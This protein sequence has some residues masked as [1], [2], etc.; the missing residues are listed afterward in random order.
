MHGL[1]E[2]V[3]EWQYGLQQL[4]QSQLQAGSLAAVFAVFA[5]GVLTS[6]TPCVYPMIPVTVT[7][8][9]GASAGRR[10]RA[11]ALSLVYVAGLA[12]IYAALG[13]TAALL[14]KTFG[15]F[16]RTWWIFGGVGLL[17]IVM[18]LAMMGW[19]DIPVPGF[20]AKV[21]AEGSRRGG[22][23]GA[24]FVGLAAG[25]VAAPCTAP[26]L[27]TLLVYVAGAGAEGSAGAVLW[28]GL[29]L[30][31]F[32]LGLG[33]LLMVL[34][35]FSGLLTNL[36]PPGRWMNLVKLVFGVLIILVGLWFLVQ[37]GGILIDS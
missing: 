14:G 26:V 19:I 13:M 27:G 22:L 2:Q 30:L 36:P 24:L 31:V 16:T 12:S 21:Q 7:Y 5:A 9:G 10:S 3:N 32:G 37:A 29:L 6:L 11:L 33:L 20:A 15:S 8:I 35:I 34:G 23:L 18:G 4:V 17:L 25:F 28:G 1:L